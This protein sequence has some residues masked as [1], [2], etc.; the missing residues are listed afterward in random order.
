MSVFLKT[1]IIARID[2]EKSMKNVQ[3]QT[4]ILA[5][6]LFFPKVLIFIYKTHYME[7]HPK[8][9]TVKNTTLQ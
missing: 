4:P 3:K 6:T 5:K 2:A 1:F 9:K 8:N 7:L